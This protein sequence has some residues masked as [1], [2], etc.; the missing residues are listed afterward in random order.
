[1]AQYISGETKQQIIKEIRDDGKRVV[2]VAA[3]H[4][5]STVASMDR[6]LRRRMGCRP[7]DQRQGVLP[8]RSRGVRDDAGTRCRKDREHGVDDALLRLPED[9]R[10]RLCVIEGGDRS[11]TRQLAREVG[12]S[13]VTVN[14]V[15]QGAFEQGD[16][17]ADYHRWVLEHQSI[18]R[19]GL[20]ADV[21]HAVVF[22]A[23]DAAS[24]ITGQTLV[25]DG[26][27]ATP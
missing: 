7:R 19:R 6:D 10:A 18:K 23:S 13:G 2:N 12:V 16:A 9:D 17:P 11:I 25:V 1:M 4:G 15:A 3:E 22:L 14:A 5:I 24:F 27:M 26:G 8:V 20:G 21:G